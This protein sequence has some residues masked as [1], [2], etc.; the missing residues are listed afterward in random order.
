[1]LRTLLLVALIWVHFTSSFALKHYDGGSMSLIADGTD[2]RSSLQDVK[3]SSSVALA[4]TGSLKN[5]GIQKHASSSHSRLAKRQEDTGL[6]ATI[7][8]YGAISFWVLYFL[9]I[10]SMAWDGTKYSVWYWLFYITCGIAVHTIANYP[11]APVLS[12]MARHGR[13]RPR[14]ASY[15]RRTRRVLERRLQQ[16]RTSPI[17][18]I[19]PA[20][21]V[22]SIEHHTLPAQSTNQNLNGPSTSG[23]R[24]LCHL[25]PVTTDVHVA[26]TG[27]GSVNNGVSA[28]RYKPGR[29][30]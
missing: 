5:S 20:T 28:H 17:T 11:Y 27:T 14:V 18:V 22:H 19:L 4:S 26:S 30:S 1:M 13:S 8:R 12:G 7:M 21:D 25:T 15:V 9:G 10:A 3:R 16:F 6:P 24:P 2:L 23:V 29:L